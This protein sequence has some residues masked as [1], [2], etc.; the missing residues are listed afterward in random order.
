MDRRPRPNVKNISLDISKNANTQKKPRTD[1][2]ENQGKD[3]QCHECE[4]DS[5]GELESESAKHVTA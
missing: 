2:K 4:D 5:E 3:V 1:E